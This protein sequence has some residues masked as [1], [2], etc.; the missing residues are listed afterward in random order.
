MCQKLAHVPTCLACLRDLVSTYLA[1]LRAHVPTCFACS[2]A[3]VP[4]C[5]EY[6]RVSRV[7]MPCM[8]M[9]LVSSRAQVLTCLEYLVSH[10]LRAHVIICQHPLPSLLLLLKLCA[11]LVRYKILSIICR[12]KKRGSR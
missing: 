7:N 6:L 5:L 1:C 4:T 2:H 11:L 3:Q 9:W 12:F 8:L 10:G